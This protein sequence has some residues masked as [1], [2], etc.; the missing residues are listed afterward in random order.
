VF[1]AQHGIPN[2]QFLVGFRTWLLFGLPYFELTVVVESP[3]CESEPVF[4]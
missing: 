1:L 3:D 4:W 2:I